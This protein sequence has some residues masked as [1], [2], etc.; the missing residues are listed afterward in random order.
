MK[1]ILL[2]LSLIVCFA[3]CSKTEFLNDY[4]EI[5]EAQYNQAFESNFGKIANNHDWGFG[6]VDY[7]TTRAANV[8]GN[9]WYQDWVRPVNITDE[10]KT[11][12]V[13]EFSKVRKNEVNSVHIDW[14][15]YW[16]Q[17]VYKGEATYNDGFGNSIGVASSNMNK[18]IAYNANYKE[19]VWWPEYKE[20][21]G[22]Y[23]H[24]NN[25]NDGNNT[26][27]YTDD[28]THEKFIGTTLMVNMNAEGIV[29]QFGYHNSVDSKDHFEYIILEIDGAYYVGF[30]FY[31]TH[32]EGQ[33]AN[34]NMDVARDWI[35]NDWIV[36]ISPAKRNITYKKRIICED[37]GAI[38]DWDFND[39]VFDALIQNGK[40]YI[41][42][43]AAG[44]TLVL[45]VA[46]KEVHNEFGVPTSTM[47]NTNNGTVRKDP[48]EFE[49]DFEYLSYNDIPVIVRSKNGA[50]VYTTYELK[51]KIGA[52]PQKIAVGTDFQWCDERESIETKY[53]SF[54]TYVGDPTLS[55]WW[56]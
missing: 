6:V 11:K 8:N 10:E 51:T 13:A 52:A 12:V 19:I 55:D 25:F 32:P 54:K 20:I 1:K 35:F 2:L 5:K 4:N 31:A 42:L 30:D 14:N 23:E 24:V 18:L 39:V 36:K 28:V 21:E 37:L 45:T 43:L 27:E 16:V 29:D 53:P 50:N 47:V 3:S 15:N 44:G 17:Q 33:E 56:K 49:I 34:K 48:V 22:G 9:L 46:G 7:G 40:T 38:G 26:I 41:K